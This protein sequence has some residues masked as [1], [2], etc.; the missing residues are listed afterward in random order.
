MKIRVTAIDDTRVIEALLRRSYPELMKAAYEADILDV[1]LPAMTTANQDLI[2]SGSFYV[3]EENG[4][5]VGC[6]GW[7][8]KEPGSGA[9]VDDLVHL[10]H[11]AV[12]PD[13]T[14]RGIGRAIFDQSATQAIVDGATRMR[15]F[16]SLNAEPFYKAMGLKR[17]ERITVPMGTI[18]E[19]PV[20]LMEGKIQ[21]KQRRK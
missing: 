7:S 3:A 13:L 5:I 11:F 19:F 12:D 21:Q 8:N 4:V 20:V 15:V 9:I 17:L 10:R 2:V 18:I 1:A 6:G 14:G 16:S